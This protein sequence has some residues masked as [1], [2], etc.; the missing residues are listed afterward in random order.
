[1]ARPMHCLDVREYRL[2]EGGSATHQ[3]ILNLFKPGQLQLSS[4]ST[5][6]VIL[7]ATMKRLIQTSHLADTFLDRV[8]SAAEER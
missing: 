6:P 4:T 5:D 8:R 3:P 1:M 7:T 2:G